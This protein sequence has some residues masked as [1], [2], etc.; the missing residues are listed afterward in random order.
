MVGL[1]ADCGPLLFLEIDALD[2]DQLVLVKLSRVSSL[3]DNVNAFIWGLANR[4]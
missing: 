3:D 4:L 2:E 1:W